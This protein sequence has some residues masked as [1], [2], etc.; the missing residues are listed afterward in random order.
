M[1]FSS[2]LLLIAVTPFVLGSGD[3]Q[4]WKQKYRKQ[5]SSLEEE[6][7]RYEI[8]KTNL[9]IV[10]RHNKASGSSFLL[11]MNQFADQV[12]ICFYRLSDDRF[13]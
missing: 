6:R 8:W 5:Y 7:Y 11:E 13:V 3:F 2:F 1:K 12:R 9:D 4:K 10:E